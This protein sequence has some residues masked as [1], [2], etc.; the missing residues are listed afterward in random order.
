MTPKEILIQARARI[1]KPQKWLSYW[2]V[3]KD[4]KRV[5]AA[6]ALRYGLLDEWEPEYL[7]ALH[8]LA[9]ASWG[10]NEHWSDY[11]RVAYVNGGTHRDVMAMYDRAIADA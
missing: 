8:R 6:H 7:D 9:E 2:S 4:G 1:D 10:L 3:S 5:C 11:D